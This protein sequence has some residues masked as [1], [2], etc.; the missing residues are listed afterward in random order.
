MLVQL[1]AKFDRWLCDKYYLPKNK[2]YMAKIKALGYE[3]YLGLH[4]KE[5][6]KIKL[7]YN[8]IIDWIHRKTIKYKWL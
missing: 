7:E 8:P 6:A 1:V 5:S 3:T 4:T 2:K